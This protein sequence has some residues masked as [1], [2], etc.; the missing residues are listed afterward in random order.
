[1]KTLK[2]LI[3]ALVAIFTFGTAH[4][5]VAIRARIGTPPHHHYHHVVYHHHYHGHHRRY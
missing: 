3:I 2:V 4:A 1:M 5:Q